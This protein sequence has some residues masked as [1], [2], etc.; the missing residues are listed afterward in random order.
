M[1]ERKQL[2]ESLWVAAQA[3]ESLLRQKSRSRW[4]NEGDCN[5]HY[6]HLMMNANQ[7]RYSI[8]GVLI[9][10]IWTDDPH[11][12]KEEVRYF[13][14]QRFQEP[15]DQRPEIDGISFKT[16]DQHQNNLLVA[17]IQEVEVQNAVWE[18]GSDKSPGPDGMNFKFIKQFWNTLK[19]DIL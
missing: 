17:P 11:K 8:K 1:M 7:N 19:P 2:Q 5:T 12:V 15:D 18:Y 10:D 9:D 13:F 16:T 6:F 4:I 14:S 3:H